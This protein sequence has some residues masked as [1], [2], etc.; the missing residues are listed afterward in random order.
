MKTRLETLLIGREAFDTRD[1]GVTIWYAPS[2][3]GGGGFPL[4]GINVPMVTE[5]F[6]STPSSCGSSNGSGGFKTGSAGSSGFGEDFGIGKG[7]VEKLDLENGLTLTQRFRADNHEPFG[8]HINYELF[9]DP[10]T[11]N[12]NKA[13]T[14]D[15]L[16]LKWKK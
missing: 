6:N 11:Q 3:C 16:E 10:I 12:S 8:E 1:Y 14:N 5:T 13:L 15:H 7:Y 9:P 4:F 2:G